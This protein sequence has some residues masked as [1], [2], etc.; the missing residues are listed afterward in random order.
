MNNS[1][2]LIAVGLML[3]IPIAAADGIG[4]QITI[5]IHKEAEGN[6]VT[7]DA[8]I[9]Q[10]VDV[11]TTVDGNYNYVEQN[12]DLFIDANNLVG[13]KDQPTNIT[14]EALVVGNVSG[15]RNTL[16]QNL[17]MSACNN[18]LEGSDLSQ[19]ATQKAEITGS[20]NYVSQGMLVDSH[21]NALTQS[22]IEQSS[23][24]KVFIKGN[25]NNIDQSGE[26]QLEYNC[27]TGSRLWQIIE[28][29]ALVLGSGNNLI[30]YAKVY[31]KNDH[32]T[33]GAVRGQKIL[34]TANLYGIRNLANHNIA[35]TDIDSSMTGGVFNQISTVKTRL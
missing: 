3:L 20:D 15:N 23:T 14:Q 11:I 29:P 33:A 24:L 25:Y 5:N 30:Q 16:N 4:N 10:D 12:V 35:L 32:L 19:K 22:D 7:G 8:L 13:T 34:E 28:E 26:E 18:D 31:T 1:I 21:D 6:C 2:A 17:I 9:V 27:L